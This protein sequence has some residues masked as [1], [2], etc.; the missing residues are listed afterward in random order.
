MLR[1]VCERLR[2]HEEK[3]RLDRSRQPADGSTNLDRDWRPFRDLRQRRNESAS[4][5]RG[6]MK[7]ARELLQFE[8]RGLELARDHRD[9]RGVRLADTGTDI[10]EH[11]GHR[12]Q[13]P[14]GAALELTLD[15]EPLHGCGLND[16]AA[17]GGDLGGPCARRCVQRGVRE[18]DASRRSDRCGELRVGKERLVM[19]EHRHLLASIDE[20]GDRPPRPRGRKRH[21]AAGLV[22]EA[23][24]GR[25]AIGHDE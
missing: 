24:A 3:R 21:R 2:A 7:A 13:T 5:Q 23:V 16:P 6:G 22:D 25:Q 9:E 8:T 12:L 11:R 14:S 19:D 20:A 17:R 1:D 15:L 10:R 4:G 18:G